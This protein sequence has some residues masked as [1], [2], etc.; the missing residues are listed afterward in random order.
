MNVKKKNGER[1]E[2]P[3]AHRNENWQKARVQR[4]SYTHTTSRKSSK[5]RTGCK[6]N[7]W[8]ELCGDRQTNLSARSALATRQRNKLYLAKDC[9]VNMIR[10]VVELTSNITIDDID[11]RDIQSNTLLLELIK[12]IF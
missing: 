5:P 12:D 9:M 11:G 3:R 1:K 2:L 10:F 7:S 6:K 8:T 4:H